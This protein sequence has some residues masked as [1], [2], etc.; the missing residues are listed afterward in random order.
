MYISCGIDKN[1]ELDLM[2]TMYER[3]QP[4]FEDECLEANGKWV[5]QRQP[6]D[7]L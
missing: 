4:M 2:C 3:R 6:G 5:A 7:K 1:V